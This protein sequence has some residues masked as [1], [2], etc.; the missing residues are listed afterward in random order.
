MRDKIQK[1]SAPCSWID[2]T[3]PKEYLEGKEN[4]L[5]RGTY[6]ISAGGMPSAAAIS[7][8]LSSA[9]MALGLLYM[10]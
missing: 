1:H 4:T 8:H 7:C 10:N 2:H 5:H 3:E 9:S 6:A